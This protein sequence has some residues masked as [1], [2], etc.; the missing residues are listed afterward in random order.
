MWWVGHDGV[1]SRGLGRAVKILHNL[2]PVH[3]SILGL[4]P[5]LNIS[6]C[7]TLSSPLWTSVSLSIKQE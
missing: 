1:G 5:T 7:V 3:L 2:V 6:L 4:S